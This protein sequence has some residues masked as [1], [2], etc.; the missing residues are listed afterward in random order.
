M[1][2]LLAL[3]ALSA[4]LAPL[5]PPAAADGSPADEVACGAVSPFGNT[6]EGDA[7][8]GST[9]RPFVELG[10]GFAGI[11]TF[12]GIGPEGSFTI[13]CRAVPL[14]AHP[15]CVAPPV[16]GT[17]LPGDALL[18]KAAVDPWPVLPLLGPSPAMPPV[19]G[20]AVGL[21]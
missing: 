5:G 19:G 8:V 17:I 13:T 6:C 18:L 7:V 11:L 14:E 3:V 16:E 21:A 15:H 12:R 20:W 1:R 2:A 9:L 10:P 4:L